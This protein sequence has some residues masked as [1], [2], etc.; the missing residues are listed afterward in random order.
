M[1]IAII[2]RRLNVRGGTQR[3]VAAVAENFKKM[4]HEAT[5]YTF[6][7]DPKNCYSEILKDIKIVSLDTQIPKGNYLMNFILE[8]RMAKKL[9]AR[10]DADSTILNPHD[11][12]SYRVAYYFKK[13]TKNIPSVWMMN[14]MPTKT[15]F[16]WRETQFDPERRP[17]FLKYCLYWLL[18]W[19]ET[20]TF[21]KAQDKVMV[22]DSRD[23]DWVHEYFKKEAV[24][25]RNGSDAGKFKFREHMPPTGKKIK[26]LMNGIFFN[27]RRFE[28]VISAASQLIADGWNILISIVGDYNAD[29]KYYA[30]ILKLVEDLKMQKEVKFAG[31]TKSDQELLDSYY[32][33]DVFIFPNHLQSWGIVPFEAMATGLPVI[34]S[35]GAGASEILTDKENAMLVDPL[36]PEQITEAVRTLVSDRGLYENLSRRGREF[37]EK[38]ISWQKYA[39]DMFK[40]FED[41]MKEFYGE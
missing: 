39:R 13:Y 9:A 26:I 10:I 15:W 4:G 36:K 24:V 3:M 19:Q 29:K 27:H 40:I 33:N 18:D 8:N 41:T 37:V 28:D 12:V 23:K 38:N 34:V 25:I 6:F 22:L 17:M 14:D 16:Y 7:Y 20:H 5:I 1:K 11:Q 21:I 2:V 30:K 31:Q 32:N 35:R